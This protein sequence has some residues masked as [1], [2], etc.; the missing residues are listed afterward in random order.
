MEKHYISKQLNF[1]F[2]DID[3]SMS[4]HSFSHSW[5]MIREFR[6]DSQTYRFVRRVLPG[7]QGSC[8]TRPRWIGS[9]WN[10]VR[11]WFWVGGWS[12]R[13]SQANPHM[14]LDH[15]ESKPDQ[16]PNQWGV[17]NRIRSQLYEIK[18]I[19][20]E[21]NQKNYKFVKRVFQNSGNINITRG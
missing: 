17:S 19:Q 6:E 12:R 15:L 20:S 8:R 13:I 5:I 4:C 14:D 3:L 1:S 7:S 9:T 18:S 10:W 11:T 21:F 2:L 16:K